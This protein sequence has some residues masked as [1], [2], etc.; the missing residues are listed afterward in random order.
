VET[1]QGGNIVHSEWRHYT[2]RMEMLNNLETPYSQNGNAIH[3]GD[4]IQ[5]EWKRY[6]AW[7]HYSQKGDT[8][9]S[10]DTKPSEW[11]H[12]TEWRHYTLRVET[13]YSQCGDTTVRMEI[14]YRL[15]TL[16]SELR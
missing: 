12:Y 10:G 14:L 4:T 13:T 9:L 8:I 1:V 3:T 6:I 11:K 15:D 2:V 7:R 16:Q 5:S